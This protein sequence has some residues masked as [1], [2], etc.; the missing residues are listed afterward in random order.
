MPKR[1]FTLDNFLTESL[2]RKFDKHN[3]RLIRGRSKDQM[4]FDGVWKVHTLEFSADEAWFH[5]LYAC[6]TDTAD[7]FYEALSSFR[8]DKPWQLLKLPQLRDTFDRL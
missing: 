8:L 2:Q 1:P 3:L 6:Q 4:T 5:T 7:T